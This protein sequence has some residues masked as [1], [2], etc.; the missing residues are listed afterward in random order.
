MKHQLYL[1]CHNCKTYFQYNGGKR[2]SVCSD[3]CK[4]S[5]WRKRK[6]NTETP[7]RLTG[8]DPEVKTHYIVIADDAPEWVARKAVKIKAQELKS[9]PNITDIQV[10]R[11]GELYGKR[12]SLE[13]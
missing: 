3:R 5:L 2:S 4:V 13:S 12:S 11:E 1:K 10:I 9:D 6:Q 7:N 8:V